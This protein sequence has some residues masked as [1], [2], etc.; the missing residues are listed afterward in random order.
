[1]FELTA[2]HAVKKKTFSSAWF[3][4]K[5]CIAKIFSSLQNDSKSGRSSRWNLTISSLEGLFWLKR[6]LCRSSDGAK[7]LCS[8][9][10][11]HN[12]ST[13]EFIVAK[14]AQ[15]LNCFK[16]LRALYNLRFRKEYFMKWAH[17]QP[18]TKLWNKFDLCKRGNKRIRCGQLQPAARKDY[19][20]RK[21]RRWECPM[22]PAAALTGTKNWLTVF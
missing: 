18:S 10:A 3:S 21:P 1:M 2:F 9:A 15:F 14:V 8:C 12:C 4:P 22:A 19:I 6:M 16:L 20:E 17:G 11:K 5:T 7:V 13:E